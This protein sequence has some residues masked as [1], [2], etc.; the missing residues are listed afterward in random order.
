MGK[1]K[2]I[3]NSKPTLAPGERKNHSKEFKEKLKEL[4]PAKDSIIKMAE[5]IG[6]ITLHNGVVTINGKQISIDI[7][8]AFAEGTGELGDILRRS[9]RPTIVILPNSKEDK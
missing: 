3:K 2:I 6:G 5:S 1:K 8:Q 4:H 9:E 7:T